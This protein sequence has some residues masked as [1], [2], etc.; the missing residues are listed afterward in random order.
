MVPV[1]M[2]VVAIVKPWRE[3]VLKYVLDNTLPWGKSKSRCVKLK[4]FMLNNVSAPEEKLIGVVE[5]C[6]KTWGPMLLKVAQR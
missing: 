2:Y 5:K 6:K 1:V 3:V 4:R